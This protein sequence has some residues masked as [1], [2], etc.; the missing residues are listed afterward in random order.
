MYNNQAREF[1]FLN[2]ALPY[3]AVN[4]QQLWCYLMVL[5]SDDRS[6]SCYYG[7]DDSPALCCYTLMT[8]HLP[9]A[10]LWRQRKFPSQQMGRKMFM[11]MMN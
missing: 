4:L 7:S 3:L 9:A 1:F 6:S 8:D 2:E 11:L 10:M 5:G